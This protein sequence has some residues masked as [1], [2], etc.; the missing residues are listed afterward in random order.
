MKD[1]VL[2]IVAQ[3]VGFLSAILLF[4]GTINIKFEWFTEA[5]ISAFGIVLTAGIFLCITLYTIYQ[6][7]YGFTAKAR[8]KKNL[9]K[10]NKLIK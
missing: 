3:V 4:L 5:S 7:F 6:N 1:Y 8:A 10:R 2:D 9:L